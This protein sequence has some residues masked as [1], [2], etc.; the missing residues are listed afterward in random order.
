ML[1]HPGG[2]MIFSCGS[3]E[4][5]SQQS[6]SGSG[7]ECVSAAVSFCTISLSLGHSRLPS[8]ESWML[9]P[10]VSGRWQMAKQVTVLNVLDVQANSSTLLQP[11]WSHGSTSEFTFHVSSIWAE[12]FYHCLNWNSSIISPPPPPLP[13]PVVGKSADNDSTIT[14]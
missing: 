9:E 5:P 1:L 11:S 14:L 2:D 13:N 8:P 3:R 10:R 6:G 4:R 7:T 12:L